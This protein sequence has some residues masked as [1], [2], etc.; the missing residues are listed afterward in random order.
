MKSYF[1]ISTYIRVHQYSVFDIRNYHLYSVLC[2]RELLSV[3]RWYVKRRTE[4]ATIRRIRP[5]RFLWFWV[6]LDS[7]FLIKKDCLA[8]ILSS[9]LL[10]SYIIFL[11]DLYS[12][13]WK[14]LDLWLEIYL[15]LYSTSTYIRRYTVI[16]FLINHLSTIDNIFFKSCITIAKPRNCNSFNL[17]LMK[18]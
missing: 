10:L 2:I 5:W 11:L 6:T 13:Q 17:Y 3:F 4:K 1:F 7:V 16:I 9:T 14:N 15:D 12:R 8:I 18:T